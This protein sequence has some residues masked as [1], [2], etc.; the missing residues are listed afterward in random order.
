MCKAL[1]RDNNERV[2][3]LVKLR[4]LNLVGRGF[5]SEVLFKEYDKLTSFYTGLPNYG[6]FK[7]VFNLVEKKVLDTSANSINFNALYSF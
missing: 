7:A 3:E 5:P 6:V 4:E 1:E 2:S